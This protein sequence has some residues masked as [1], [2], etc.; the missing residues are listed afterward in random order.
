MIISIKNEKLLTVERIT[1][2]FPLPMI[3][4]EEGSY[5]TCKS[6]Y[7]YISLYCKH[8]QHFSREYIAYIYFVIKQHV[9]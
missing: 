9:Y 4:N 3:S 1:S 5:N 7:L 2:Y 6:S 8:M